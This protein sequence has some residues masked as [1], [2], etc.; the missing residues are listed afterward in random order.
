MA[1][2]GELSWPHYPLK[3]WYTM[4]LDKRGKIPISL[5][6]IEEIVDNSVNYIEERLSMNIIKNCL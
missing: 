3:G 6:E 1:L 2:G 5:K 4:V